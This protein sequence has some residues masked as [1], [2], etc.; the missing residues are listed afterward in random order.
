[1]DKTSGCMMVKMGG[2]RSIFL[3]EGTVERDEPGPM[4]Q[5]V[6]RSWT[7]SGP[8]VKFQEMMQKGKC[9]STVVR[10]RDGDRQIQELIGLPA[11][12]IHEN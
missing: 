11:S 9:G 8:E 3:W 4:A 7:A 1:M 2:R 10:R 6:K 5:W 12:Q